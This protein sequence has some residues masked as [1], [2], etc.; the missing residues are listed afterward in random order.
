ENL[1]LSIGRE[2]QART[3]WHKR[4]PPMTT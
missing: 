1:L 3:D 2:F 4:R